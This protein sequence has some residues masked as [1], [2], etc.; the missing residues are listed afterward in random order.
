LAVLRTLKAEKLKI[1]HWRENEF[2]R[3]GVR[4]TIYDY[5][6]ADET[7]LPSPMCNA[8]EVGMRTDEVYRHVYRLYGAGATPNYSVAT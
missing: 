6:V 4:Q 7:G 3:D 5:R 1:D 2:G 8:D